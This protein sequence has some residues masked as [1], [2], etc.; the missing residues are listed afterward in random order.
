[1]RCPAFVVKL[2]GGNLLEVLPLMKE[3]AFAAP[4][5]GNAQIDEGQGIPLDFAKLVVESV[6]DLVS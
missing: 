6:G 4:F 1:M 3:Q 2:C 5:M